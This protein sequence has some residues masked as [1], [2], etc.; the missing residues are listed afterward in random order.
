MDEQ[1]ISEQR[2]FEL[3]SMDYEDYL[4]TD[5][6]KE[7]REQALDRDSYRCRLCNTDKNLHVHHRTYQRRGNE[8]LDDLTTLCNECHE[9]FHERKYQEVLMS[10]TY[11]RP[12]RMNLSDL[13]ANKRA[14]MKWEDYTLGLLLHDPDLLPHVVGIIDDDD[15]SQADNRAIYQLL[16]DAS[17]AG[18]SID[19][20]SAD[21]QPTVKRGL[22]YVESRSFENS[23]MLVKETVQ[24]ATRLK[25]MRLL[26]LNTEVKYLLDQ[27]TEAGDKS[28]TRHYQLQILDIS[29]QLRTINTATHLQY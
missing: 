20:I 10:Q 7:K 13:D 5:E 29:R 4:Q 6:W 23:E 2:I 27:A 24:C 12:S 21:L 18:I 17:P 25:R 11:V 26:Q 9:A 28:A 8:D 22:E 16:K 3:R 15:F 14:R 19:D 1:Q